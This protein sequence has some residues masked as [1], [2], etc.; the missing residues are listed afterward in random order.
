MAEVFDLIELD[1]IRVEGRTFE[2][3]AHLPLPDP[4]TAREVWE[5]ALR[6]LGPHR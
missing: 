6:P 5:E 2:G 1:L 4:E 3:V